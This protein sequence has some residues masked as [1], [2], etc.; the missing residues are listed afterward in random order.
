MTYA[1]RTDQKSNNITVAT[2]RRQSAAA[3]F[4]FADTRI[5]TISQRRLRA[6]ANSH[7]SVERMNTYQSLA[8]GRKS[9]R[10]VQAIRSVADF[11][12]ATPGRV[13]G[14]GDIATIDDALNTYITSPAANK[15]ANVA[16]L[17]AAINTYNAGE[18]A[19]AKKA[20]ALLLRA[21][22]MNEQVFLNAIGANTDHFEALV[23]AG[24]G[25]GASLLN[26]VNAAT[27][28]NVP[29]LPALIAT[30]GGAV[31]LVHL[32]NIIN[33]IGAAN[34]PYLPGVL[35]AVGGWAN[36]AH[37]TDLLAEVGQANFANI[38]GYINMAGGLANIGA[39]IAVL[40]RNVGH[41]EI[42]SQFLAA[43]NGDPAIFTKL[44]NALPHFTQAAAPGN[45]V[46]AAP[47]VR[48][49]YPLPQQLMGMFAHY[50]ER[51]RAE[52]FLFDFRSINM[53]DGQTIWP[54]PGTTSA[55]LQG[56]LETALIDPAVAG[57]GVT[58]GPPVPGAVQ[59][60]P[61][62]GGMAARIRINNPTGVPAVNFSISQ[63]FPEAG[64]PGTTH[65]T[66]LEMIG[67]G[68]VLGHMP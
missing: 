1:H 31:G 38:P 63:F 14:R 16:L 3:P 54:F 55:V 18:H 25:V 61:V 20:E 42:A 36:R 51:H 19:A 29:L 30:A 56:Y 66:G 49:V 17:I 40:H 5:G 65:F 48:A 34:V 13:F 27:P 8:N 39:L 68:K 28:A 58:P 11:Q 50:N 47:A 53:V 26:V 15:L 33:A 21:E 9:T 10:T 12:A 57:R 67:M 41:P 43:V 32:R 45:A 24:G 62:G 23:L 59:N 6:M 64:T 60:V 22:A 46:V 2:S 35:T 44:N 37:I 7:S 52:S 4:P